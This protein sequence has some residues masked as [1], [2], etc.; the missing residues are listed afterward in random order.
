MKVKSYK[1][2]KQKILI[3]IAILIIT[4][5]II[6]SLISY[7]NNL[8]S[9][10]TKIIEEINNKVIYIQNTIKQNNLNLNKIKEDL[11]KENIIKAKSLA[12]MFLL[13]SSIIENKSKIDELANTLEVDEIHIINEN[14]ILFAGNVIDFY[15]FDFSQY[16]QTKP[17]LE[18]LNKKDFVLAQEPQPRGADNV[19]F[20]YIGVSRLDSPGIVQIGVNPKKLEDALKIA[21]L[22]NI[23]L[24]NSF[25]YNGKFYI[26]NTLDNTIVSSVN[27][28]DIGKNINDFS[29]ANKL[30]NNEGSFYNSK[31]NNFY[32]YKKI[33]NNYIIG[34]VSRTNYLKEIIMSTLYTATVISILFL[35]VYI[36]FIYFINK[37]IDKEIKILNTDIEIIGSG[38]LTHNNIITSSKELNSLSKG[39][40]KMQTSIKNIL[41][42]V[43]TQTTE[44][45]DVFNKSNH[46]LDIL[47]QQIKNIN[48]TVQNFSAELEETAASTEQMES[49]ILEV[50]DSFN[51]MTNKSNLGVQ[52]AIEINNKANQIKIEALESQNKVVEI[53][54]NTQKKIKDAIND[55]K[56]IEEITILSDSILQIT[57]QTSLLA[58]NASIEAARAGELGKGFSVVA[59]EIGKLSDDSKNTVT[60]IQNVTD[61]IIPSV[62]M[63]IEYSTSLLEFVDNNI[64]KDY[65]KFVNMSETYSN[66]AINFK[67]IF[68]EFDKISSETYSV[69]SGFSNI[70][71]Q[72][73]ATVT[74]NANEITEIAT[75]VDS[76]SEKSF[77]LLELLTK[78][79]DGFKSLQNQIDYFK[80]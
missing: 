25:S 75:N 21:D 14:G 4:T 56:K 50:N 10:E 59:D 37:Y 48:D 76:I 43:I 71:E 40:S 31:D 60:K 28:D 77:E 18:G 62:K 57:H 42:T 46:N 78:S 47:I 44:N 24:T 63:L 33:D 35:I 8:N 55:S 52:S 29:F 20:Q 13:D 79:N 30:K 70:L 68:D 74:N 9:K 5:I 11:N 65:A 34:Y 36:I 22:K 64:M 3:P 7:F 1:S 41:S 19:L 49:S 67:K 61:E 12:H 2:I 23:S 39:I 80:L 38:D 66:D 54:E 73:A 72:I 45:I 58:L 51:T 32:H 6:S 16:D 69:L 15:G 53:Y 27:E 26:I 17:F